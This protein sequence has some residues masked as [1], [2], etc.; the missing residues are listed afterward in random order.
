MT[1]VICVASGKGGVG[2]TTMTSNI[3]MALND[4]GKR[5]LVVDANLTTPNLG[6]HLGVPLYPKTLH[7]V[8]RGEAYPEEAT[9]IHPS[10]LNVMPASISIKDLKGTRPGQ[11]SNAV[12]DMAGDHDIMLLDTAA[13]LGKEG[14][15]TLKAADEVLIVTSPQIP[16]VTDALKTIKMA[17]ES[18]THVIGVALNK[19]KGMPSELSVEEV[20]ALLGHPV[21]SIVPEDQAVDDGL[22]AKTPVVSYRPDAHASR[23][24]KKL[25]AAIIGIDY[26]PPV[27]ER[28]TL[29]SRL[30]S[31]LKS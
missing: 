24:M 2:K 22:A 27:L 8:L 19:V 12:L 10:G 7:D 3:G 9:Y 25:A 30:F 6:F 13:G 5:V 20:E 11:M 23:E 16:S 28:E 29:F 31:F 17:E 4:F 21:I 14:L 18:G 1:R 26:E 15:E